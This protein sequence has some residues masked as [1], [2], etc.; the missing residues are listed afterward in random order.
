[1]A[2]CPGLPWGK[3]REMTLQ[4]LDMVKTYKTSDAGCFAEIAKSVSVSIMCRHTKCL[5]YGKKDQWIKHVSSE[6]YR[7]PQCGQLYKPLSSGP[8]M[9]P[10]N[11][12]I[13]ITDP[14]IG[15]TLCF[16]A[17]WADVKTDE[18]LAGMAEM[19]ASKIQIMD[20]VDAFMRESVTSLHNFLEKVATPMHLV[21]MT[22]NSKIETMLHHKTF[23]TRQW[24]H[25]KSNG[26]WGMKMAFTDTVFDDRPKIINLMAKLLAGA[27][28]IS[29]KGG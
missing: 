25:L 10:A 28:A 21:K 20:N 3:L 23:P 14:T 26:V 17:K 11:T 16:P 12:V 29:S 7:C 5:F 1:M 9:C 19:E 27:K 8:E 15:G 2:E 6:H 24:A 22:W 18:W 4:H 13:S